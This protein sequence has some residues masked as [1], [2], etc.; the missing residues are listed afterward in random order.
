MKFG[1][2]ERILV[3]IMSFDDFDKDMTKCK[4]LS[5]NL[6]IYKSL[7]SAARPYSTHFILYDDMDKS[8]IKHLDK[9]KILL[10]VAIDSVKNDVET[11]I[12]F[13]GINISPLSIRQAVGTKYTHQFYDLFIHDANDLHNKIIFY[14]LSRFMDAIIYVE[15][16][17]YLNTK[18]AKALVFDKNKSIAKL[19]DNHIEISSKISFDLKDFKTDY[20]IEL[21]T[22]F[23]NL[24]S[25]YNGQ[26]Y[27]IKCP[28]GID[29]SQFIKYYF[30]RYSFI[31]TKARL[32]LSLDFSDDINPVYHV[33]EAIKREFHDDLLSI[34]IHF[35]QIHKLSISH[36]R[37]LYKVLKDKNSFIYST[38][39]KEKSNNHNT[40]FIPHYLFFT[41]DVDLYDRCVAGEFLWEL[42]YL[43]NKCEFEIKGLSQRKT[44]E[45]KEILLQMIEYYGH[46]YGLN[47]IDLKNEHLQKLIEY[48]YPGNFLEMSSI[49][50]KLY[51]QQGLEGEIDLMRHLPLM[52]QKKK[53]YKP[54]T[55]LHK[56][57]LPSVKAHIESLL[58]LT[59]GHIGKSAEMAGLAVNTFKQKMDECDI[60]IEDFKK[61]K[62][63]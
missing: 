14:R 63:I 56:T 6:L 29:V 25:I 22:H 28:R 48:D 44:K 31:D 43:I 4:E 21:V 11:E 3:S 55:N 47:K 35:E 34:C 8:F 38:N 50:S 51:V 16:F 7:I 12:I 37:L 13:Q 26:E 57:L 53:E 15:N 5:P 54:S 46:E 36:Q 59:D 40:Y 30:K 58:A 19:L 20:H 1:N 27:L 49:V 52:R 9:A 41:T 24:T 62:G 2:N 18:A 45:R 32:F 10:K 17:G 33:E 39:L 23:N 60:N 42:Y 61:M